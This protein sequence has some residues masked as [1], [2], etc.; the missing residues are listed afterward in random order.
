M[1]LSCVFL[2]VYTKGA[3]RSRSL[4]YRI[5]TL[6]SAWKMVVLQR[7]QD[8]RRLRNEPLIVE[9]SDNECPVLFAAV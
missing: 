6:P 5:E 3:D 8:L 2:P 4:S 9:G 1:E 7:C